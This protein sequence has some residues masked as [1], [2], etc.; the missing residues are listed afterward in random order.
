ML[1]TPMPTLYP[2][3]EKFLFNYLFYYIFF[4]W[5]LIYLQIQRVEHKQG[6]GEHVWKQG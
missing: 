4:A 2:H 1:A 3:T 5:I 6:E